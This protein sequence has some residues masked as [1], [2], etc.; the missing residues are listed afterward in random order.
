MES[1]VSQLR[2]AIANLYVV[3]R[4]YKRAEH[5]SACDHCTTDRD[6]ADLHSAPLKQLTGRAL[7]RFLFKAMTTWG[8]VD[9]FRHFLP[10]I[11][12]LYAFDRTLDVDAEVA[13]GKLTYGQWNNWPSFERDAVS[14]YLHAYWSYSI[15]RYPHEPDIN[16][17]VCS[18]VQAIDD[19]A[20]LLRSWPIS[21]SLPAARHFADFIDLSS[22]NA[23]KHPPIPPALSNAFWGARQAQR[24]QVERW[25]LSPERQVEIDEAFFAFGSTSEEISQQLSTAGSHLQWFTAARINRP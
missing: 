7:S 2:S 22:V 1:D 16:S 14:R 4:S 13:L 5:M 15:G 6:H 23:A 9:D 24:L 11:L 18:V 3:F 20:S 12:E 17:V 8:T 10:R 21:T 19:V 25:L